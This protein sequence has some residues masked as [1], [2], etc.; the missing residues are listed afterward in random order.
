MDL[1][2]SGNDSCLSHVGGIGMPLA[3]F[4]LIE[5]PRIVARQRHISMRGNGFLLCNRLGCMIDCGAD[6]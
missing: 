4:V 6:L 2:S 1:A 5:T 3:W